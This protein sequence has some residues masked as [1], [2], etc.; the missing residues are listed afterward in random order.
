LQTSGSGGKETRQVLAVHT[1]LAWLYYD[2]RWLMQVR[3][4]TL[5]ELEGPECKEVM[6][7]FNVEEDEQEIEVESDT[8]GFFVME[9]PISKYL[10]SVRTALV[11]QK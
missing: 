10:K 3:Y 1:C 9:A 8:E 6:E 7:R 2:L 5:E 11:P 4:K